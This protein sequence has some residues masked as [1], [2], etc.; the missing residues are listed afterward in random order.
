MIDIFAYFYQKYVRVLTNLLKANIAKLTQPV[1]PHL[2]RAVIF[3]QIE[4]F[5]YFATEK[6]V[7]FTPAQ[8][9]KALETLILNTG[10][11]NISYR[12]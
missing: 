8:I 12:E 1:V 10:Q 7:P 9:L 6:G 5:Q 11:Y 4:D 2:P 3:K